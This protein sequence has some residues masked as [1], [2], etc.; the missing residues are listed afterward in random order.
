MDYAGFVGKDPAFLNGVKDLFL[1]YW[2]K[3]KRI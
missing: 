3:G 1:F 2:D